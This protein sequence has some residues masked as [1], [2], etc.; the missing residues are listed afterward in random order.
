MAER[1]KKNA[2][3]EAIR[4]TD[5]FKKE[6]DR[7][8]KEIVTH[9]AII[10]SIA[11][12]AL[13]VV[14][15]AYYAGYYRVFNIPSNY[16]NLDLRNYLPVATQIC[17]SFA[18]FSFY[19]ADLK[20]DRLLKRKRISLMRIFWGNQIFSYILTANN[21]KGV[22]SV[23]FTIAVPIVIEVIFLIWGRPRK[24]KEINDV[25]Y[26]FIL[27]DYINTIIR[28]T[29]YNKMGVIGIVLLVMLA[30]IWGNVKA[31]TKVNYEILSIDSQQYAI[32]VDYQDKAVVQK[33]SI[34]KKELVIYSDS[35]MLINKDNLIIKNCKFDD[36]MIKKENG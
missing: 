5:D 13:L 32:V 23:V 1:T 22:W 8:V 34:S 4:K 2:I 29:V 3:Y 33:I 9:M 20:T 10:L 17:G 26:Q 35:Y 27:E 24:D 15:Y 25:E 36:V 14:L 21:I 16:Y 7:T 31:H 28:A 12:V 19:Y 11:A 30:P 18:Y 6:A